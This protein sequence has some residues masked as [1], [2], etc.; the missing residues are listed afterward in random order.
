MRLVVGTWN[1]QAILYSW[2]CWVHNVKYVYY[3]HVYPLNRTVNLH[4]K[5]LISKTDVIFCCSEL[6]VVNKTS[7]HRVN[8]PG[9][10]RA[11][12]II[13]YSSELSE[14]VS[15]QYNEI[16]LT[17]VICS[18]VQGWHD[19]NQIWCAWILVHWLQYHKITKWL[20][21]SK[22]FMSMWMKYMC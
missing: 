4:L 10:L 17:N 5:M 8:K 11:N 7:P 2:P 19:G 12:D 20:C 13:F 21:N 1:I 6:S 15:L 14:N 9:I 22:H 18:T 16:F 3:P